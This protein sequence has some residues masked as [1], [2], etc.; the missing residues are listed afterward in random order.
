MIKVNKLVPSIYYEESR[1]FQ[2]FGRSLEVVSNYLKTNVD[3]INE[4]PLDRRS[5]DLVIKLVAKTLGFESK[6]EYNM[7]DLRVICSIFTECLRIKGT[8]E[9]VRMA[10]RGLLN[11]QGIV[12]D[13]NVKVERTVNDGLVNIV[14]NIY[15]PKQI[16]D[17]V[18]LEDLF[19]YILPA[20]ICYNFIY[21][22]YELENKV[23]STTVVTDDV[24]VSNA[25]ENFEL[26]TVMDGN[27]I[28]PRTDESNIGDLTSINPAE[29]FIGTVASPNLEESEDQSNE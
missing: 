27:Q 11:A 25:L 4:N 19:D 14:V 17:V 28:P 13:Y 6:H 15:V 9:S 29:T 20:G 26:G 10:V 16:R 23:D 18:L 12:D 2:L 7:E 22:S 21:G 24:V 3:L 1:D 8:E 5:L